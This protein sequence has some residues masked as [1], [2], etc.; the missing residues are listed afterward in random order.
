[1]TDLISIDKIDWL[2]RICLAHLFIFV[3]FLID[4]SNISIIFL[5]D[6]KISF[7]IMAVYS[8]AIYRPNLL[9]PLLLFIYGILFDL[10][11]SFPLGFHSIILLLSQYFIK[12]QRSFFLGQPYLMFWLGYAISL[13]LILFSEWI[14][15]SVLRY[16]LLDFRQ[17][18]ITYVVSILIFP[19]ISL[20]F[21]M[22]NKIMPL[23]YRD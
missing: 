12:S 2:W 17:L 5:S 3:F 4:V 16:T 18:M 22:L 14:F 6:V 13:A 1:M 19:L 10:I 15:F 7:L 9:H 23:N 21:L 8:W 20:I 11:L